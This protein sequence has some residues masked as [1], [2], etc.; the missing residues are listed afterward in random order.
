MKRLILLP[1]LLFLFILLSSDSC[2]RE[3]EIDG[4]GKQNATEKTRDSIVSEFTSDIL[5]H[6]DLS[7]FEETAIQRF[8]DLIDFTAFSADTSLPLIFRVKATASLNAL[9][10]TGRHVLLLDP[11]NGLLK[12]KVPVPLKPDENGGLP[13]NIKIHQPDSVWIASRLVKVSDSLYAGCLGFSQGTSTPGGYPRLAAGRMDFFLV[14]C[15]RP[16]GNDTLKVWT[17]ALGDS[18]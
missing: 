13:W 9:F 5:T 4:A 18:Y 7:L 14:K 8:G 17:V 12:I 16:F 2:S 15:S 11:G 3:E 1:V 10:I 6:Q